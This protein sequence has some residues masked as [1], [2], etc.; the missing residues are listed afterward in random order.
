MVM[1]EGATERGVSPSLFLFPLSCGQERGIEG[2]RSLKTTQ[3]RG[4]KYIIPI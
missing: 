1:K 2:V 4:K 3:G